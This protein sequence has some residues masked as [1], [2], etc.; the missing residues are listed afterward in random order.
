MYS[1]LQTRCYDNRSYRCFLK[2][3]AGGEDRYLVP[4]IVWP[5]VR[6]R[7]E[8]LDDRVDLDVQVIIERYS[9]TPYDEQIGH[10]EHISMVRLRQRSGDPK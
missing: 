1:I 3:H 9:R 10:I 6:L 7:T 2:L 8:C 5:A 4:G